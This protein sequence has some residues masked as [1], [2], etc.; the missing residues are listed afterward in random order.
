M[1]APSKPM[2]FKGSPT[3]LMATLAAP[4]GLSMTGHVVLADKQ[5]LPLTIR[6]VASTTPVLSLLS[7]RLPKSTSPGHYKG[8]AEVG[9]K[10]IPI[11]VDVE[12][13]SRLR[14]VPPSVSFR[15]ASGALLETEITVLNLGNVDAIIHPES[16]FCIFDN[17]GVDQALYEALTTKEVEG[18]RR[19]DRVM[20]ELAQSHGGLV[21]VAVQHGAGKLAPET[22]RDLVVEFQFSHRI[23][24]G[25]TYRGAWFISETSLEVA[26]EVTTG[27]SKG[28]K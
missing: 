11:V 3:R 18:K 16:T 10:I 8:S 22:S 25:R 7:F 5:P 24:S 9:G 20:D 17:H 14:F 13:R 28:A 23:R 6:R 2:R 1:S 26:I 15:G 21:R 4:E 19:I 12:A 27:D